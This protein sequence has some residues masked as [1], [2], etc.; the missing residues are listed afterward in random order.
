MKVF[1]HLAANSDQITLDSLCN[2]LE[3]NQFFPRRDD[4]EAILRRCDHDAN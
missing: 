3:Q 1:K 4:L 2:F